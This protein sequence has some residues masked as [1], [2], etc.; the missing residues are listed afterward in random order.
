MTC[1]L[2]VSAPW[3]LG[4]QTNIV[5]MSGCASPATFSRLGEIAERMS[6]SVL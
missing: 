5:S 1:R 3:L 2:K 6:S 4:I